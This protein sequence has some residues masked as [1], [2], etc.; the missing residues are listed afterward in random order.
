MRTKILVV[1]DEPQIGQQI[2]A[3][4]KDR[5]GF[6]A[7]LAPMT[8]LYPNE[9]LRA[10]LVKEADHLACVVLDVDLTKV[11]DAAR[12]YASEVLANAQDLGIPT[13]VYAQHPLSGRAGIPLSNWNEGH[14]YIARSIHIPEAGRHIHMVATGANAIHDALSRRLKGK[15]VRDPASADFVAELLGAP[16]GSK[17]DL[18]AYLRGHFEATPATQEILQ[19]ARESASPD[20][21]ARAFSTSL[22]YWLHNVALHYPGMMGDEV[23]IGSYLDIAPESLR[24]ASVQTLLAPAQYKGPM[25]DL[26]PTWWLSAVNNIVD[27]LP[28]ESL[29]RRERVEKAIGEALLHSPCSGPGEPHSA[30]GVC[31]VTRRAV[32]DKHGVSN[33]SMLPRP[34]WL[35]RVSLEWQDMFGPWFPH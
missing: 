9:G 12:V 18:A 26:R 35:S 28:G 2:V 15:Q 31:V 32:C 22:T 33:I 21:R 20:L 30:G 10:H 11:A 29:K 3:A 8:G 5:G 27:S 4:I 13:V 6:D 25:A 24:K 34:A 14:I 19:K 17:T 7:S 23:A 1:D 16:A